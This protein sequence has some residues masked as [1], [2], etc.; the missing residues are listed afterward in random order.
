MEGRKVSK[1]LIE[2]LPV[3][4]YQQTF[5]IRTTEAFGTGFTIELDDRQYFVTA[6]HV[7]GDVLPATIGILS[8]QLTWEEIPVSVIGQTNDQVDVAVLTADRQLAEPSKLKVGVSNVGMGQEIRFLGFPLGLEMIEIPLIRQGPLPLIKAGTLSGVRH[9]QQG[10]SIMELIIDA[11]GNPGY[12]GGPVVL[13][14]VGNSDKD[15]VVTWHIAGVIT[16]RI[17]ERVPVHN[18][19]GNAI[20]FVPMDAGIVRATS[21]DAAKEVIRSNPAGFQ[22]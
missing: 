19:A 1:Q 21:I 12:S 2:S 16:S 11:A 15:G 8:G 7:L 4:V 18:H 14:R 17:A 3:N 13:P 6:K 10:S 20:G 5:Q 9:F 22:L